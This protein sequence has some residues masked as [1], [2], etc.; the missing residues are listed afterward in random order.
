MI[1]GTFEQKETLKTNAVMSSIR[2]MAQDGLTSI[3]GWA[4]FVCAPR[5]DRLTL[6]GMD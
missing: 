6:L 3:L 2:R 1:L 4:N 5:L